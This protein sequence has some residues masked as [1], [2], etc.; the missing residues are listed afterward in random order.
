M[1]P[2]RKFDCMLALDVGERRIGV[3]RASLDAPFPGP[4]TTLDNPETFAEDIVTLAARERAAALVVGLPRSLAG[5]D[6]AQTARVREFV[7]GLER[8]LG[9]PV[10]WTDEALTSAKAEA[11]LRSRGKPYRKGDI[12]ALAATYILEDYIKENPVPHG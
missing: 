11:E 4:L 9:I 12:D 5:N 7:R 6:T 1:E 3:A 10:Y 8:Q 2:S